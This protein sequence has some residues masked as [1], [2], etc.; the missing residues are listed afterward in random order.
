MT[1]TQAERIFFACKVGERDNRKQ[2]FCGHRCHGK[3]E[4][5]GVQRDG[6]RLHQYN[7]YG[8]Q[9]RFGDHHQNVAPHDYFCVSAGFFD[10][11]VDDVDKM[12]DDVQNRQ[13]KVHRSLSDK[14]FGHTEQSE[15]WVGERYGKRK[16]DGTD[17]KT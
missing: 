5:G 7:H 9:N 1:D 6:V 11:K 8:V 14:F 15:E 12:K 16:N 2:K 13:D 4:H 17:C 3:Q 10:G